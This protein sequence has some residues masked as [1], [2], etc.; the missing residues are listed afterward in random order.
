M[1]RQ[2]TILICLTGMLAGC[3]SAINN[4]WQELDALESRL[5]RIQTLDA[6]DVTQSDPTQPAP[7]TDAQAEKQVESI[8]S[9][10]SAGVPREITISEVRRSTIENNLELQSSLILPE[11]ATQRL[12]AERAKFQSTFTASVQQSRTIS[13]NLE[14]DQFQAVPGLEVPLQTGGTVSLDWTITTEDYSG[15]VSGGTAA[16]SPGITLQQ[17]LLRGAGLEY[18]EASI[19]IAGANL[20]VARAEAQIGV[21][22]QV[23]RAEIAYWQLHQAW[24]MLQIDLELYETSKELLDQQRELVVAN[25]GSIANV[26][27]FETLAAS[28]V[29]RVIQA[30]ERVRRA[31]RAVKV[32]MQEPSMSLDASVALKPNTKLQ[33]VGLEFDVRRLVE[34]ALQNRA[35]LLEL[36]F[37]QLSRTVETLMRKNETLPQ[38]DLQAAW[39]A[40]GFNQGLSI[41]S[42]TQDVFNGGSP[43]GWS[44]GI[45]ASIPIGNEIALANYQASILERLRTVADIR[46]QEILVTQEVLDA[47][48][49]IEAGWNSIVTVEF[50]VRA[51]QRFYKSYETLFKRGQIPSSNLTQALQTLNQAKIQRV[52]AE[53]N[54]QINLAQLAQATGCLLGHA[55][56]DWTDDFD[57]ER[58]EEPAKIDPLNGL[59]SGEGNVLEDGRP[60]LQDLINENR[61]R[62]KKSDQ[63]ADPQATP[64]PAVS[65]GG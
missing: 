24:Q 3:A 64:S 18:N 11:I 28:S 8:L 25:A 58:L 21:I 53:V 44:I 20:G 29:D 1:K 26:Y 61:R 62:S 59:P 42:A 50:Q 6:L 15:A 56:V 5:G 65:G 33:L 41:S 46:Q 45:N 31:V 63:E 52:V 19:V 55:G 30:E 16:S 47:I 60:T 37:Q 12:R 54:Y 9:L 10:M 51:A 57:R 43:D 7:M 13:T 22:N 17:P 39:N 27:N 36:E 14:N 35:E 40:N 38:L 4:D 32:I 48:D 2:R 23:I 34:S 49:A